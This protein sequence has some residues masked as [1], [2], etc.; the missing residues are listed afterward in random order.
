[1]QFVEYSLIGI[2]SGGIYVLA[3]LGW[4]II[5]K[6]S[7]VFN[8]AIPSRRRRRERLPGPLLQ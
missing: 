3:A 2:A 4:V 8:F 5:Y 7:N 1:M 6:S